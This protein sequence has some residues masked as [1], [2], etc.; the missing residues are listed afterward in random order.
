MKLADFLKD[1]KQSNLEIASTDVI[2]TEGGEKI[3]ILHLA[4]PI[5]HVL[6]SQTIEVDGVVEKVEEW[7]VTTV[8][9]HQN[10]QDDEGFSYNEDGSGTY[11]GDLRLDVAKS[12]GEVW[13]RAETFAASARAMRNENTAKRNGGTVGRIQQRRLAAAARAG[14]SQSRVEPVGN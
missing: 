10:E 8:K 6:G 13:L 5:G 3:A 9:V 12:S 14:Q 4:T 2:Y 1:R 11:K 7:D